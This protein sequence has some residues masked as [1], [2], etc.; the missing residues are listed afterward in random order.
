[1]KYKGLILGLILLSLSACKSCKYSL[2]G[3]NIPADVSNISIAY[4]NNQASLVNPSISQ[5]FTEQLKDKFMRETSLAIVPQ[6]GDFKITGSITD[7][8]IQPSATTNTTEAAK[9]RFSMTVNVVFECPK[10]K[11]MNFTERITKFQ[12]F[13]A[14]ENFQTIENRLSDEV[15]TQIIQEIFNKVALKW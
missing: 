8:R 9:N 3:I 15:S 7:Y 5:K 4:F 14:T 12:E 1:M 10:H 2:S 6:N 13:N 11:E